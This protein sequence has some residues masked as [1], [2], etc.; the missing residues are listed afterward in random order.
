[1]LL[2][3]ERKMD[4]RLKVLKVLLTKKYNEEEL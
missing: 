3:L 4:P 2:D 1:M